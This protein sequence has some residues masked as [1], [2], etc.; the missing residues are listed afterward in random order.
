MLGCRDYIELGM[1]RPRDGS[2]KQLNS[3]KSAKND[4]EQ[5][6]SLVEVDGT[7]P[8][9]DLTDT[10]GS[11]IP[12]VL[13]LGRVEGRVSEGLGTGHQKNFVGHTYVQICSFLT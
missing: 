5:R 4:N 7:E 13:H 6:R 9:L 12:A 1:Y 11:G 8:G 3:R 10:G 2:S